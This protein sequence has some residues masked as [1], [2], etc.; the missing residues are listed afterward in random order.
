MADAKKILIV[1][2]EL[3]VRTWLATFF[4]DN[5]YETDTAENGEEGFAKVRAGGIDLITLDITMDTQSGVRMFRDLQQDPATGNIPVIIITGVASE[6]KTF[7][8][9]TKQVEN[10]DG[11]FEKPVDREALLTKVRELIG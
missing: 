1:D 11:Y 6:F 10:P 8:E 3:D 2:D 9:R 5:G 7:I 4:E